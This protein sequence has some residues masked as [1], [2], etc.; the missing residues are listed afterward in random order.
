MTAKISAEFKKSANKTLYSIFAFAFIYLLLVIF[1]I[2]LC[3]GISY[4]GI[5]LISNYPHLILLF[6]AISLLVSALFIFVFLFKFIFSFQRLDTSHLVKIDNNQEP[7]LFTLIEE[8]AS[9]VETQMPKKVF[10]SSEINASVFYNSSFWSMFFP[11]R[12]NLIIGLGLVNSTTYQELKGILAHEFGHFS[13]RSMRVGSYVYHVN[14]AIYNMLY[15]NESLNSLSERWYNTSYYAAAFQWLPRI[16][17]QFMQKILQKQYEIINKNYMALSRE[18]EFHADAISA[19]VAG[20]KAIETSLLRTAFSNYCLTNVYNFYGA[21]IENNHISANIFDDQRSATQLL[22][23]RFKY[24]LINGIPQI[25]LLE[26]NKYDKSKLVISDQWASHPSE[27]DRIKAVKILEF[28]LTKTNESPAFKILTRFDHYA[29]HFTALAFADGPYSNTPSAMNEKEFAS[30]FVSWF[31]TQSFDEVFNDFYTFNNPYFDKEKISLQNGSQLSP[32]V[33]FSDERVSDTFTLN[34]LT[35]DIETLNQIQTKT[36]DVETFDY[37]GIKYKNSDVAEVI[38]KLEQESDLLKNR[39][40]GY[41]TDVYDYCLFQSTEKQ[42][43]NAL[44]DVYE[45]FMDSERKFAD[46]TKFYMD[47]IDKTYFIYENHP[48]AEI[49]RRLEEVKK[50]E[51]PFKVELAKLINSYKINGNT[52]GTEIESKLERYTNTTLDYFDGSSYINECLDLLNIALNQ[53]YFILYDNYFQLKK[54]L[55][56]IQKEI[57]SS[58]SND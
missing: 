50:S 18:M 8:I 19:E 48:Y 1:T 5:L 34:S 39:V 57:L 15:R 42:I 24:P 4:I 30:A 45:A 49:A 53:Y 37:E 27:T 54:R 7:T 23:T 29:D 51:I 52:L 55:L 40:E 21:Q 38:A 22:S 32:A 9:A 6:L 44:T 33:L 41:N 46:Q 25:S 47:M 14:Q 13:Q 2:A 43:D 16:I 12:K 56:A 17:I 28:E 58:S 35:N 36:I 26:A 20:S 31:E 10:L 11:V 3:A